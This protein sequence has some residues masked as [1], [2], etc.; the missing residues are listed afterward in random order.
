MGIESSWMFDL[1]GTLVFPVV[2]VLIIGIVL[3]CD[4]KGGMEVGTQQLGA[5]IDRAF[6]NH[7]Q[8]DEDESV[9]I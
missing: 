8:T 9:A 4:G 1:F 2:F 5:A 3:F 6:T 7:Q